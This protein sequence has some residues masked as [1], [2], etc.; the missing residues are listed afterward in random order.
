MLSLLLFLSSS[1]LCLFTANSITN[2]PLRIVDFVHDTFPSLPMANWS[3]FSDILVLLQTSLT[4]T[5]LNSK[6]L[7]EFFTVMAAV[8]ICRSIC[9]FSTVLPPL[10]SYYDKY[11]LGGING[12]GTEYIFS[13]HAAYSSLGAIYLWK[14][15]ILP[16]WFI[17]VYNFISQLY[18][19]A[20]R[21]HYSVD[22]VLAWI[23][24]P[25]FYTSLTLCQN[26]PT[27]QSRINFLFEG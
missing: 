16:L 14:N 13:G 11:R 8:Q 26:V 21:N 10:K 15:G 12:S 25:L 6:E 3:Y 2:S 22:V 24:T 18:I 4:I 23:I 1:V 9:S 7:S 17:A 19:V 5:I 27:C 20:S